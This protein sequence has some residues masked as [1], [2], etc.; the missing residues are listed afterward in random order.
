VLSSILA[1]I[2]AAAVAVQLIGYTFWGFSFE[3]SL[4]LFG[5][6]AVLELIGIRLSVEKK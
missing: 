1:F 5:A 4:V 2:L 3:G 6:L